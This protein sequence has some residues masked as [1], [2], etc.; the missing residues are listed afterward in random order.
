MVVGFAPIK[1]PNTITEKSSREKVIPSKVN[2]LG[3]IS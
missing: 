1:D 3:Y 2:F